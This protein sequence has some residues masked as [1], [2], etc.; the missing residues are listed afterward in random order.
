M[1]SSSIE[2]RQCSC[3]ILKNFF[4]YLGSYSKN[5]EYELELSLN[6]FFVNLEFKLVLIDVFCEMFYFLE[7]NY[8]DES[9]IYRLFYQFNNFVCYQ[10]FQKRIFENS[11]LF[12]AFEKAIDVE[13]THY[14]DF[15]KKIFFFYYLFYFFATND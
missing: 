9:K 4:R 10:R 14:K 3:S 6:Y 1:N 12:K 7:K 2:T 11:F 8:S 15:Q 5:L 13:I